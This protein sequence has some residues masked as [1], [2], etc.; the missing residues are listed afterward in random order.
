MKKIL[1]ATTALVATASIAAAELNVTG[2]GSY[3][4]WIQ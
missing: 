2:I 3:W 4:Y 1:I